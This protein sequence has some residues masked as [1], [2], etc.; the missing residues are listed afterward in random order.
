M[1]S[2]F[3]D[4]DVTGYNAS[5]GTPTPA[6]FSLVSSGLVDVNGITRAGVG[7]TSYGYPD[8]IGAVARLNY[9]PG[10]FSDHSG[11]N[12][13]ASMFV[14]D[15]ARFSG[16]PT[17]SQVL[18]DPTAKVYRASNAAPSN[19]QTTFTIA[20]P[21]SVE[22]QPGT[23]YWFLVVPTAVVNMGS[24]P[25]SVNDQL[26]G[27]TA[28][29]RGLSLWTNR[30]P[31]KPTITSPASGLTVGAGTDL[32]FSYTAT[33]PDAMVGGT[34]PAYDDIAGVQVQYAP[35]PTAGDPNPEWTDLEATD[36]NGSSTRPCVYIK[37][38]NSYSSTSSAAYPLW[39]TKSMPLDCGDYTPN[40]GYL[41]SGNWQVRV[42]VFDFRHPYPLSANPLGRTDGVLTPASMEAQNAAS[43]WSDPINIFV[44]A[45]T[46]PPL[47]LA[48]TKDVAIAEGLPVVLSWQFRSTTTPP[49][50]QGQRSVEIREVG[51]TSWTTLASES[52][53]SESLVIPGWYPLLAGRHYEWRV[54]VVDNSELQA[55]SNWSEVGYFW[56]VAA[57]GSGGVQPLPTS[58]VDNATLGCGTHR[59]FIYRRGGTTRVGEISNL[60]KI[61]WSRLRDDISSAEIDVADW[62]VDCGAL[63][64]KLQCWAYELVIYRDNG[65]SVDR[66]WEGPITK[67]TY[68][69]DEVTISAKDVMGYAYRRIIKEKMSDAGKGN[70]RS[71]VDRATRVLQNSLASDD[72]NILAYL[73]PLANTDDAIQ[74]RS[75][76]A[77][78]R[79]AFEEVDDMAANAGL[80]YTVMGRSI[81]LWGT[82]HR[83]GTLP[84]FRDENFGAAP[85]VSEYGMS[86]ANVYVVSDGN[87]L[88]GVADR[89]D[90]SGNDPIYGR[91]EM[92]SSTW[93]SDS[94]SETGTYT[95]EGAATIIASFTESA[96]R[97]IDDRYPVPVVVRVPDNTS[98]NPNTVLSIQHLVPGVVIP[99]RSSGTLRTVRSNQKLDSVTVTEQGG[100]ET[101]EVVMSPFNRDDSNM[102]AEE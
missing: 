3:A 22:L 42:R 1:V 78:S 65:Y 101:I 63:L 33:D 47:L 76:P 61:T 4:G 54:Q 36:S 90:D 38:S 99:L 14:V 97:S 35:R 82:K 20:G 23:K 92:L 44:A 41:P 6:V 45:Q 15:A 21:R 100:V 7:L 31:N 9:S 46:P 18:A 87:G 12:L 74:Y 16:T 19:G 27:S 96:E 26:A 94:D 71:V 53:S 79:T 68:K 86:M 102:E 43:P 59:A 2:W 50:T 85:I 49:Y 91:V 30:P 67:L 32:T 52:S 81:L 8:R 98:L 75:T 73:T 24:T 51:Q 13:T 11:K 89:L 57:P 64:A 69:K 5:V 56:V 62:G 80:D 77:Y 58:T 48:P 95:A 83:I 70:G 28:N 66:V 25:N 84:E 37:G 93:A 88:A 60:T 17:T 72:P 39:Q 29:G 55:A 10:D 34:G 40:A